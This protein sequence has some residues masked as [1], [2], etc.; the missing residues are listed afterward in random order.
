MGSQLAERVKDAGAAQAAGTSVERKTETIFDML[1]DARQQKEITRALGDN[2]GVERFTRVSVTLLR[3]SPGLQACSPVSLMGALMICAQL[4]LEPGGPLGQAWLVPF[5][6]K[7]QRTSECTFIVGYKGYIALALRSREIASVKA[8][9]VYEGDEFRWSLGLREDLV[10]EPASLVRDDPDKLTHVYAIARF[11]DKDI[12]P[13]F[14]VLTRAE[15]ESFRARSRAKDSGPWITDYVAMAL[16]TAVRRLAT[17]LPM[18]VEVARASAVDERVVEKAHIDVDDYLDV[19]GEEVAEPAAATGPEGESAP[20]ANVV[21][22]PDA[23]GS[24]TFDCDACEGRGELD[25]ESC[26][27]CGGSGSAAIE[28][29]TE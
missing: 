1:R 28:E 14:V 8:T 5:K 23:P 11:R 12:D 25:G 27:T 13:M 4:G 21:A 29:P 24:A 18:A 26:P 20:E 16:K 9:A 10:H 19:E 6:K 15:V 22:Q 3:N 17:W 2:I 7:G